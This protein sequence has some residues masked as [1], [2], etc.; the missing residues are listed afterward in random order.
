MQQKRDNPFLKT[1]KR[2]EDVF[3]WETS[4]KISQHHQAFAK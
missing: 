1:G 3:Y 2:N 4:G